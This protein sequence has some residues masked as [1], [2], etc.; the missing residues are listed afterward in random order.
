MQADLDRG[1][2]DLEVEVIR[3]S[4]EHRVVPVER[5]AQSGAVLHVELDDGQA[6]PHERPEEG[7]QALRPQISQRDLFHLALLQQIVRAGGSLQPRAQHQHSHC[8]RA[9]GGADDGERRE[10]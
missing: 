5:R 4:A 6:L 3:Q 1:S 2:R 7:G 10:S 9:S 8:E